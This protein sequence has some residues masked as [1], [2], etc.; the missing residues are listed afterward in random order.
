L[1]VC[2]DWSKS[3][4]RRAAW[5]AD[6]PKRLVSPLP[7]PAEGWTVG[8]LFDAIEPFDSRRPALIAFDAPLGVPRSYLDA[9]RA[10]FGDFDSFADWLDHA[11]ELEDFFTPVALPEQWAVDRPFFR[12][13]PGKGGLTAFVHAAEALGVALRREI[14]RRHYAKSVFAMGIPGHVAHAAQALWKEL[15]AERSVRRFAMW[16]FQDT[17]S[18]L[19]VVAEIY[20]RA[21]YGTVLEGRVGGSKGERAVRHD[22]IERLVRLSWVAGGG[23]RLDGL[24]QAR[25]NEDDFDAFMTA[26]AIFRLVL[27]GRP[28][29]SDVDRVAEGA[30]LGA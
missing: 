15:A 22:V 23:V 24:E 1:I 21:A 16:P 17:E 25:S 29:A 13:P 2:A 12:V 30:M 4:D 8:A 10:H 11:C 19:P 7:P 27:E 18:G 28:L 26:L 20:P 5:V 3:R 9:Y 6:V 14:E